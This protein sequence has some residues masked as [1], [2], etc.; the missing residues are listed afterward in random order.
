[1][2]ADEKGEDEGAEGKALSFQEAMPGDWRHRGTLEHIDALKKRIGAALLVGLSLPE[3]HGSS[4]GI[5]MAHRGAAGRHLDELKQTEPSQPL[6][7][8]AAPRLV[9][10]SQGARKRLL[11]RDARLTWA[12]LYV[13]LRLAPCRFCRGPAMAGRCKTRHGPDRQCVFCEPCRTRHKRQHPAA[14]FARGDQRCPCHGTG[15]VLP[16]AARRLI[17]D[18]VHR[19]AGLGC[20]GRA[21]E[22]GGLCHDCLLEDS[23]LLDQE[24]LDE[25]QRER[26]RG[27]RGR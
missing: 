12:D 5:S 8:F 20:D 26:I 25:W 2:K 21:K 11:R 14:K 3:G 22:Q 1:M 27:I 6:P 18:T 17:E 9:G 4:Y 19:C 24:R 15:V 16:R 13:G 23:R 7:L 10:M